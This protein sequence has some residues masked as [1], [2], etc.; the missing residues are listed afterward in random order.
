[1][2]VRE[3][4]TEPSIAKGLAAGMVGGL[5]AGW[6]MTE[7]HVALSGRGVTGAKEPQSHRP[8]DGVDDPTTKSAEV[9]AETLTGESLT[10]REKQIGGPAVHY[11]F[12]ITMGALYG[13]LAEIAPGV[14]RGRGTLF[15]SLVWLGAAEVALP[16][17]RLAHRPT[18]YPLATHAEMFVTH[19]VFGAANDV[20]TRW[21]R[22]RLR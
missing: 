15:G 1:M 3:Q 5:I 18:R 21:A 16:L 12:S 10:R 13:I 6:V 9:I 7:C 2:S 14:R 17:A 22:S 20:I 11:A 4:A 19:L 8:V